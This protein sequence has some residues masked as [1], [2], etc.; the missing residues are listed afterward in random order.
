MHNKPS[1]FTYLLAATAATT[2]LG[3]SPQPKLTATDNGSNNTVSTTA[4]AESSI[5]FSV[6]NPTKQNRSEELVTI[7]KAQLL[8][9]ASEVNLN[10]ATLY[11]GEQEVASQTID[12]DGDG[13]ADALLFISQLDAE[14]NKTFTLSYQAKGQVTHQYPS[15]A[16]AELSINQGGIRGADGK[17]QGGE[18]IPVKFQQI[19]EDHIPGD[20]QFRYEGPGWES[21]KIA[22]RLYFDERNVNDIFGKRVPDI[23]LPEVGH[24]GVSYH[25]PAPW[26]MDILKVG[27]SLGIG[28]LGMLVNGKLSRVA[29]ASDMSVNIIEQG[30]IRA[31]LQVKH[32]DWAIAEQKFQLTSDL[33]LSAG[34]RLT[35]NQLTIDGSPDNLVTGIVKHQPSELI[36]SDTSLGDWAYIA[37]FGKQS[38]VGDEMGMAIFYKKSTLLEVS[39][40]SHNHL[41]VMKPTQGKLDY[42]F[43]GTWAQDV[44]GIATKQGFVDYLEQTLAGLNQPLTIN[45]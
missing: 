35:H 45:L 36:T 16:H 28:G 34:S 31:H 17:L 27:P 13:Q 20:F 40:D 23:V 15:R 41:V 29:T 37:T 24:I 42:Y 30:P 7:A 3:C 44:D 39:E 12:N 43:A 32:T 2:L 18:F 19:P 11:Q 26:G 38:Y 10:A 4:P 21:D 8:T 14:Q 1:K 25:E 6:A 5:S 33:T 22:Y 9:L